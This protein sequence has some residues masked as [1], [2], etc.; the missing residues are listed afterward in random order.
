MEIAL[1][2]RMCCGTVN[3]FLLNGGLPACTHLMHTRCAR[4]L[5]DNVPCPRCPLC[6]VES[7]SATSGVI[8]QTPETTARLI[9]SEMQAQVDADAEMAAFIEAQVCH[10]CKSEG[11]PYTLLLCGRNCGLG[12]HTGCLGLPDSRADIG[13][14]DWLCDHCTAIA[15]APT[16]PFPPDLRSSD[17]R[18]QARRRCTLRHV[19]GDLE[20][21]RRRADERRAQRHRAANR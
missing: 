21:R 20:F 15:R 8:R 12:A 11:D 1:Y 10:V 9:Q 19:L 16:P 18:R 7:D 2:A 14:E 3:S 6:R 17:A 4:G 13:A 5:F